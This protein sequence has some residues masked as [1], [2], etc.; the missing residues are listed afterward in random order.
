VAPVAASIKGC[1]T[2]SSASSLLVFYSAPQCNARIASAVLAVEQFNT[3][4]N[5]TAKNY[6]SANAQL[7]VFCQ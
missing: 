4:V 7:K 1:A 5:P 3:K 6:I 2:N